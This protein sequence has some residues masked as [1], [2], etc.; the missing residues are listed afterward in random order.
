[1]TVLV[2]CKGR[3]ENKDHVVTRV[4]REIEVT[5]VHLVLVVKWDFLD[6]PVPKAIG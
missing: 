5:L 3:R 4:T 1:M 2:V 6:L